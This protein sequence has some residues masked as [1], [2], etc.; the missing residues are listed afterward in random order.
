[1]STTEDREP[2]AAERAFVQEVWDYWRLRFPHSRSA[3][4]VRPSRS[5][6]WK[7]LELAGQLAQQLRGNDQPQARDLQCLI[8]GVEKRQSEYDQMIAVGDRP[9]FDPRIWSSPEAIFRP[10]NGDADRRNEAYGAM[11]ELGHAEM[12]RD[13]RERKRAAEAVES[14]ELIDLEAWRRQVAGYIAAA[15]KEQGHG[16]EGQEGQRGFWVRL[17]R[18]LDG[19][20]A[21]DEEPRVAFECAV[22]G[23]T[24]WGFAGQP[25][26]LVC[27]AEGRADW[28]DS[29]HEGTKERRKSRC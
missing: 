23:K 16:E 5:L 22:C 18:R 7:M 28:E 13:E 11:I 8:R 15:A 26:C 17:A 21:E 25:S 27:V 12:L 1:M 2:T 3:E 19:K 9:S 10:F 29:H 20:G 24:A 6:G 14:G 4:T